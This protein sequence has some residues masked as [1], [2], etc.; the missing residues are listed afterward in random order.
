MPLV[1]RQ[2]A[3]LYLTSLLRNKDVAQQYYNK[4]GE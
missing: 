1:D 4:T 2:G 3:F